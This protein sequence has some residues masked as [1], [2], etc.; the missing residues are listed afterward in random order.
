MIRTGD[1]LHNPAT[2]ELMQ[3]L[4]TSA[5][6]NGEYVYIE[7]VVEP[8]GTVAAAHL[9]PYQTERF[10]IVSGEVAFE[11]GKREF[12]AKAG[13]TVVVVAGTPHTFWNAGADE[14]RF[15]CEIR[16]AL[17]FEQL[18]E[19][20]FTLAA[21]GKTNKKGMPNPFR[22]AV[23]ANAHFDDVRLP[24]PPAWMQ[25]VGLAIGSPLGSLLGYKPVYTPADPSEASLAI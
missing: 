11:A 2:G 14:A 5:D 23:I 6:T 20:M 7:V 17:R 13:E 10:E 12:V 4:K 22:L 25:K 18:I 19:T 15:R 24:F 21:D 8:N 1:T 9:H 16:P 3:F